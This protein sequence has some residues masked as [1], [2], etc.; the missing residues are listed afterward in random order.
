MDQKAKKI[1]TQQNVD[2]K[3]CTYSFVLGRKYMLSATELMS[4]LSNSQSETK[5]VQQP[6][7][8]NFNQQALTCKCALPIP[9]PQKQLNNLGGTIKIVKIF[10]QVT[11]SNKDEVQS[12]GDIINEYLL[13]KFQNIEH[14]VKYGISVYSLAKKN[15]Q[16]IKN[17]LK[18]S[19]K[20]LKSHNINPRFINKNF[21]SLSN[22]I[23]SKEK[24]IEKG[25]EIV[26][27]YH[28][29]HIYI[30]ETVAIQDFESYS[31]RD[32]EKPERDPK[33]GMLPPKIAQIMINLAAPNPQAT[34]YDPFC[35][36]GTILMEALLM[37]MNV[38][39]SDLDPTSIKATNKNIYWLKQQ[40]PDIKNLKIDTFKK[41]A[42]QISQTDIQDTNA[43]IAETYLGPPLKKLPPSHVIKQTFHTL[44]TLYL[45]FFK[46]LSTLLPKGFPIVIAIPA[47]KSNNDYI[48]IEN[49][50]Q[51]IEQL[52]Y[53]QENLLPQTLNLPTNKRN[54]LIYDR[55]NQVVAREIIKFKKI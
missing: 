52:G 49:L 35:G 19:K 12:I 38:K 4:V 1:D 26:L 29:D 53:K 7:I 18:N 2:T 55:K 36:N 46:N 17:L 14:K 32:Y 31:K 50:P 41:D 24:I 48:Y 30:G 6:E 20:F 15:E 21:K 54:S 42:T 37:G 13:D 28:Q 5:D 34:I 40:N 43:I 11:K 3:I 39:G 27:I 51:K 45:N 16:N 10:N 9:F 22:V 33:R 25:A 47:Y 23:I 8:L 44:S